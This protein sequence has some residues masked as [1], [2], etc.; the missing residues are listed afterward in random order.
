MNIRIADETKAVSSLLVNQ[1]ES[2]EELASKLM[3]F[4]WQIAQI[5]ERHEEQKVLEQM[6]AQM[7]GLLQNAT[8]SEKLMFGLLMEMIVDRV[9]LSPIWQETLDY[10]ESEFED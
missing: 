8:P 5:I 4:H 3:D 1:K 2:S 10:P 6:R 9:S 7:Q